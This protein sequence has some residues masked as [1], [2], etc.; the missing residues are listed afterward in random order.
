MKPTKEQLEKEML[1]EY[2]DDA[3]MVL[4][5]AFGAFIVSLALIGGLGFLAY[6][7]IQFIN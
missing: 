4:I 6:A 1:Q 2:K 7:L 5:V 3:P